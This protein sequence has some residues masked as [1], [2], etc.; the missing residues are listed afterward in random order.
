MTGDDRM[1]LAVDPTSLAERLRQTGAVQSVALWDVPF[2]TIERQRS[3]NHA[4]RRS[5]AEAFRVFTRLPALWK[6]RVLH[7]MGK[8]NGDEGAKTYYRKVRPPDA[9]IRKLPKG[10][11]PNIVR[12]AKLDASYW[13]GLLAFD[14]RQLAVSVDYLRERVLRVDAGGRWA[15]GARYNLGR[16]YEG[17]GEMDKARSQYLEAGGPQRNGN[18]LRADRL[19]VEPSDTED[20]PPGHTPEAC[21]SLLLLPVDVVAREGVDSDG[22]VAACR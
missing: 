13:L 22:G 8:F 10:A 18:R 14:D 11:N 3:F 20:D 19:K 15:T 17:L 6:A 5:A 21:S 7:F 12:Q 1:V 9:K 4:R 16:A 2:K